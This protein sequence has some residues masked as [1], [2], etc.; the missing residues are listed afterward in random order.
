[1]DIIFQST[2]IIWLPASPTSG[3]CSGVTSMKPP[4][5]PH[6]KLHPLNFAPFLADSTALPPS[7]HLI[8][9]LLEDNFFPS[10]ASLK[11]LEQYCAHR[12][13]SNTQT[14]LKLLDLF[15]YMHYFSYHT[16]SAKAWF[17]AL[18]TDARDRARPQIPECR[19][20]RTLG[21]TLINTS[22]GMPF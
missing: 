2:I 1:M 6:L 8:T 7:P 17:K 15:I 21:I 12:M 22:Q 5:P 4:P 9:G 10:L 13:C 3:F 18:L 16:V 14:T 20:G 19:R 11:C